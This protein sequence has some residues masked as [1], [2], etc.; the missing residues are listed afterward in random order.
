MTLEKEFVSAMP[1]LGAIAFR[2]CGN[3]ALSEDLVQEALVRGW[4][5]RAQYH[6]E[7]NLLA[8]LATIL[9]NC[10]FSFLRRRKYE[11]ED[12]D[13]TNALALAVEPVYEE[14]LRIDEVMRAVDRLPP[15]RRQALLLVGVDELNYE[16]A[17]V[18]CGCPVGTLKSRIHRAR[19]QLIKE[20]GVT[21][22]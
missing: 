12:I 18:V 4:R 8:W 5:N 7:T 19:E 20:I 17:A 13:E 6:D 1:K 3:Y 21:Y 22:G 14:D 9:R 11:L 16:Q 15:K 10:Y 2:L